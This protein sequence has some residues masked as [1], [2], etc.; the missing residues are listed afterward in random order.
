MAFVIEPYLR[1]AGLP[2]EQRTM[3]FRDPSGNVIELFCKDGVKDADKLPRGPSR[4]HG[5]AVDIDAL[6]YTTWKR[7]QRQ[8]SRV[9]T[10]DRGN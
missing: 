4:G 10:P 2:G 8:G 6:R 7:P 3:F 5:T 9:V 1:F